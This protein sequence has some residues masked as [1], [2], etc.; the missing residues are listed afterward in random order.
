[1]ISHKGTFEYCDLCRL[2]IKQH[3]GSVEIYRFRHEKALIMQR[4]DA[5]RRK[6]GLKKVKRG[7]YRSPRW[8]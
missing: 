7:L 4:L 1:M 5:E 3:K 6:Q 2:R 8:E